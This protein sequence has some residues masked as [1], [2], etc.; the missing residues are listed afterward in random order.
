MRP[1][2]RSGGNRATAFRRAGRRPPCPSSRPAGK[3][4]DRSNA[5][6]YE[7]DHCIQHQSPV[8]VQPAQVAPAERVIA[9]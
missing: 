1:S 7:I 6:G 4:L 5:I 2:Q 8:P 9:G 3:S